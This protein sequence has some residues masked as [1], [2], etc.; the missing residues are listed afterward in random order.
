MRPLL[1]S[2]CEGLDAPVA[3]VVQR[4]RH[5]ARILLEHVAAERS[6]EGVV[7]AVG[8][9]RV[10]SPV[11]LWEGLVAVPG[12][13]EVAGLVDI[14]G[15]DGI[16]LLLI[17]QRALVL[18]GARHRHV[19]PVVGGRI[20]D[21]PVDAAITGDVEGRWDGRREEAVLRA[22]RDVLATLRDGDAVE[23]VGERRDAR[24]RAAVIA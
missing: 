13:A 11:V 8:R 6:H 1:L 17:G 18:A 14:A 12:L 23:I 20:D 22:G 2:G 9:Q 19:E 10:G 21:E 15:G 7:F 24:P 16:G 4:A 5:G 3:L